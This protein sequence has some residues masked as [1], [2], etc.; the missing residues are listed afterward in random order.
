MEYH[1]RSSINSYRG[2]RS[3]E[4]GILLNSRKTL[5]FKENDI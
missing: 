3:D 1:Q 5:D 2:E 4:K